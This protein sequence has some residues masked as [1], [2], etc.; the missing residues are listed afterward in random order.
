M[1]PG[2]SGSG[3]PH[4]ICFA[5]QRLLN[6]CLLAHFKLKRDQTLAVGLIPKSCSVTCLCPLHSFFTCLLSFKYQLRCF[7]LQETF[8]SP[9]PYHAHFYHVPERVCQRH[10]CITS[11]FIST[12]RIKIT[13]FS[14]LHFS[15]QLHA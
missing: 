2:I 13:P 11:G 10:P 4:C 6:A 1:P 5:S 3:C 12:L 14:S 9:I 8:R 15:A 7:A